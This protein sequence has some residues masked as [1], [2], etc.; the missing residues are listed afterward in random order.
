MCRITCES[1]GTFSGDATAQFYCSCSSAS[2]NIGEDRGL[3]TLTEHAFVPTAFIK[4]V[5]GCVL[6]SRR[7][8]CR[9]VPQSVYEDPMD[10]VSIGSLFHELVEGECGDLV[11]GQPIGYS[12]IRVLGSRG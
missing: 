12:K 4:L 8:L 3:R 11:L 1:A 5:D 6:C 9:D 2:Q 7:E 10:A